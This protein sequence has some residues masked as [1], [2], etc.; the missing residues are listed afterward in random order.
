MSTRQSLS[1]VNARGLF[2]AGNQAYSDSNPPQTLNRTITQSAN[3]L[4]PVA[5]LTEEFTQ[6]GRGMWSRTSDGLFH[7]IGHTTVRAATTA[8]ITLSAAQTV[9]GVAL[10]AGDYCLVKDQTT[11]ATNGVY[12]VA[13]GTWPRMAGFDVAQVVGESGVVTVQAGTINGG[14]IYMTAFKSTDTLGT[15]AMAWNRLAG[16]TGTPTQVGYVAI[17]TAITIGTAETLIAELNTVPVVTGRRYRVTLSVDLQHT[18]AL[19]QN[20]ITLRQGGAAAAVTGTA[21]R[22]GKKDHRA[23]AIR[24]TFHLVSQQFV[25]TTTGTLRFSATGISSAASGSVQ[26]VLSPGDFF[27]EE[28]G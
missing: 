6:D 15:T 4:I 16:A 21:I 20:T 12:V 22:Q 18:T 5:G 27:V 24:E 25:A 8:N 11:A 17:T 10:V 19:N 7:K 9:D 26:G 3:T 1:G 28:I 2:D 23:A 14:S 13:A